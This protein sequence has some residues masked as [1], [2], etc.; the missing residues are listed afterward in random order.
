LYCLRFR[1]IDLLSLTSSRPR[2]DKL[3]YGSKF[4]GPGLS[5]ALFQL[6]N[7]TNLPAPRV[8][9]ISRFLRPALNS[10]LLPLHFEIVDSKICLDELPAL[11]GTNA[12][13]RRCPSAT[14]SGF[15]FFSSLSRFEAAVS[16][17]N[18]S[19]SWVNVRSSL[20]GETAARLTPSISFNQI[21]GHSF[22]L[23][24]HRSQLLL[25][26]LPALLCSLSVPLRRLC[27]ILWDAFSFGIQLAQDE[28][29]SGVSLFARFT[30][31]FK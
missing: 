20:V 11:C 31:A 13:A 8:K 19:K 2:K 12:A 16:P 9:F 15:I 29:R 6:R 22:A 10:S 27:V 4:W 23:G 3:N 24:I 26:Q 21:Q 14:C 25:S 17:P 18:D 7:M 30:K 1:F 5:F 28:L